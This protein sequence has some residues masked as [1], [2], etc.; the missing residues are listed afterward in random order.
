VG[1]RVGSR[2]VVFSRSDLAIAVTQSVHAL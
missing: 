2:A 1:S